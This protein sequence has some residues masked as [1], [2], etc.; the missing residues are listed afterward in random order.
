LSCRIQESECKFTGPNK[1]K[2]NF[3]CLL[4]YQFAA[5]LSQKYQAFP[6]VVAFNQG[7]PNFHFLFR[8]GHVTIIGYQFGAKFKL[9]FCAKYDRG[10]DLGFEMDKYYKLFP[11]KWYNKRLVMGEKTAVV[12]TSLHEKLF[13]PQTIQTS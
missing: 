7:L 3:T 5:I 6:E 11:D 12:V 1:N 2:N 10:L 13:D 9:V 8:I 4:L